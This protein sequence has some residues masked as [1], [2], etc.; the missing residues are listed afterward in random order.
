MRRMLATT[1]VILFAGTIMA[2]ATD[3]PKKP[4]VYAPAPPDWSGFYVGDAAGFGSGNLG[5]L[6]AGTTGPGNLRGIVTAGNG[7]KGPAT[8]L[9]GGFVGVQK[10]QGNVVLGVEGPLRVIEQQRYQVINL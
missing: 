7:I 6:K 1:M 9:T 3:L 5:T 10:Q 4:P 8:G 2:A